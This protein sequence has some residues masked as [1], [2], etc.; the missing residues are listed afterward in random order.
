MGGLD[1][2]NPEELWATPPNLIPRNIRPAGDTSVAQESWVIPPYLIFRN[3]VQAGETSHAQ[4]S[5]WVE[6]HPTLKNDGAHHISYPR[7][8]GHLVRHQIFK[9]HV[10]AGSIPTRLISNLLH[11]IPK[12]DL[13]A[14]HI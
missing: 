7:I 4:Q 10:W 13:P 6:A 2:S 12:N 8:L 14:C 1:T 3:I 9:H 5:L 11:P